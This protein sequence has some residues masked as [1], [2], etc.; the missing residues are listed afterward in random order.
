MQRITT[1]LFVIFILLGA[2]GT[3]AA[4]RQMED[5]DRGLIAVY[6]GQNKV[7]LS[8]RMLG[9]EPEN[10]GYNLYRTEAGGK[11]IKLNKR[12]LEKGTNF[13]DD[14]IDPSRQNAYFVRPVVNG[15]EG[16]PSKSFVLKANPEPRLCI[17]QH[18]AH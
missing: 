16:A 7:F 10:V 14:N 17:S 13:V 5:L 8:W 6:Q 12:P 2:A 1:K 15:K 18:R 11:P 4:Q 9:V 3:S